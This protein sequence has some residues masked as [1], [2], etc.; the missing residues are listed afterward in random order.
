MV[1]RVAIKLENSSRKPNNQQGLHRTQDASKELNW[2][3]LLTEAPPTL[4]EYSP[5][6]APPQAND[7]TVA[8]IP[9]EIHD[10]LPD[11][12][13]CPSQSPHEIHDA[14]LHAEQMR[15][16]HACVALTP[17]SK[18]RRD[19]SNWVGEPTL[20]VPSKALRTRLLVVSTL[21]DPIESSLQTRGSPL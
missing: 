8:I 7:E 19:V 2:G 16:P 4:S 17:P 13:R 15:L 21:N 12:W 14:K 3:G 11:H 18:T 20:R 10:H 9:A 5:A 1:L 6:P